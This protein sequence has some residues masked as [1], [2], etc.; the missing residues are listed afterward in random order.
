VLIGGFLKM[1]TIDFPGEVSSVIFTQG[2]N[3]TCPY[4]HNHNLIGQGK[5]LVDILYVLQTIKQRIKLIDSVVISGG[6]PTL[7]VGLPAL[8]EELKD[9]GVKVKLD[10]NGTNPM[11]LKGLI[12][13][14][15]VDYVAMDI[16]APLDE[17]CFSAKDY[18]RQ[19]K[20]SVSTIMDSGIDYEFR[21][22]CVYPFISKDNC[23]AI[24]Y[25]IRGAKKLFLQQ[26]SGTS[27][28]NESFFLNNGRHL[29]LG[30][31][32]EIQNILKDYIETCEVR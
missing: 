31:I 21:T 4:C 11:M 14:N 6:E 12:E 1:S 8:C 13:N 10:T 24:G 2:C 15:L 23:R 9:M 22:T 25:P 32:M 7:Q 3:F 18:S 17:Y 26:M 5:D 30:E 28:F 16:K 29:S 27:V 19:L 20:E